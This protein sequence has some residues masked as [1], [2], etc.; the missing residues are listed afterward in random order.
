MLPLSNILLWSLAGV[1]FGSLISWIPGFHIF[2]IMALLVA[3]FG[4]GELMPPFRP[5]PPSSP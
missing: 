2:N 3:V 1:L 5:S 4:V